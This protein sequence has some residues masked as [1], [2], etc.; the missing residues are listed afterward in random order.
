MGGGSVE[1]LSGKDPT[2]SGDENEEDGNKPK[3]GIKPPLTEEVIASLLEKAKFYTSLCLGT[4]AIVSMFAF[5]FL[6]PFVVD[7]AISTIVADY[8][9]DPVTC[10][11]TD[12]VYAEGL[13]N[14]S[15]S[16]CR[17]GC[18]N[19]ATRCHQILVNYS[20][21]KWTSFA[22]DVDSLIWDVGD[23][24]FLVNTEGCGYPPR[25]NCSEFAK[26]YGY[27][28]LGI[29][30]PCYYSR[31]YPEMVVARYSWDDNL[32]HLV[33]SLIIPN[34]L[35]AVSIGVLSYWYCACCDRACQRSTRVYAEKFPPKEDKLLCRSDDEDEFDE[36]FD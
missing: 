6:I 11:A 28:K 32:R 10:M 2:G 36:E 22:G 14:C 35:F 31:T 5:L 18:T 8:D 24:R 25:V 21:T 19:A 1:R 20:R 23:T 16:S 17:E 33:L 12:H 7:P 26:A 30:F 15:W 34:V 13:R 4:T 9:P 27:D 29:P 3:P